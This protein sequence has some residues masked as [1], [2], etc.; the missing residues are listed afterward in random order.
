MSLPLVTIGAINYNNSKYIVDTLNSIQSQSYPNIYLLILDDCSTDNSIS[1]IEKWL[2]NYT[3]PYK[4]I[5]HNV[6]K[7]VCVSCNTFL[8]NIAGKYVSLIATD[9][10]M[11]PDKIQK[12]VEMLE[13][14]DDDVCGVYSDAFLIQEDGGPIDNTLIQKFWKYDYI[15]SGKIFEDLLKD[16]FIGDLTMLVKTNCYKEIGKYDESLKF[17][18]Y[19]MLLRL[20]YKYKILFSDYVSAKYRIR[21]NSLSST[22]HTWNPDRVKIYSKHIDHSPIAIKQIESIA[23]G[24]F[25]SNEQEVLPLLIPI[26]KRTKKLKLIVFFWGLR[27]PKIIR[28]VL[29]KLL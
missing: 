16:N 7:G 2:I 25:Y 4:F 15:P 11:M 28:R 24:S 10:I 12:Q 22:S 19:D 29:L 27:L 23:V 3:K 8:D 21:S 6:N 26:K 9:D 18:D 20:S 5:K 1:L 14:I 17:E 13:N